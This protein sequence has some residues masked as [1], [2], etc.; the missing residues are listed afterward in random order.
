MY[1]V[2]TFQLETLKSCDAITDS[3][4]SCEPKIHPNRG[5]PWGPHSSQVW[6]QISLH[7]L[8]VLPP[9]A[10]HDLFPTLH[11]LGILSLKELTE[12]NCQPGEVLE[13]KATVS[14]L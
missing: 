8:G 3:F 6:S 10:S 12:I 9:A 2:E 4:L 11:S 14:L 5:D 7:H 13:P 1:G